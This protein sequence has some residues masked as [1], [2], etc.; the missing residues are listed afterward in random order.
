MAVHLLGDEGPIHSALLQRIADL[1]SRFAW[2][3]LPRDCATALAGARLVPI[4]KRDG[5]VRPIA[6]GEVFRRLAG[7]ALLA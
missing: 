6:V 3:K 2:N 4:G 1:T 5:G 7:K